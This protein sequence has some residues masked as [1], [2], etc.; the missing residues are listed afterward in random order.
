MALLFFFL[1]F[2]CYSLVDINRANS[3]EFQA[4]PGISAAIADDIVE[5]RF[6]SPFQVVPDLLNV[7]S[8]TAGLFAAIDSYLVV[9]PICMG[10]LPDTLDVSP[11]WD[12]EYVTSNQISFFNC[13]YEQTNYSIDNSQEYVEGD[14]YIMTFSKM[15][16][17]TDEAS[18]NL[19]Q[20]NCTVYEPDPDAP[21][22]PTAGL[23][24]SESKTPYWDA[25]TD[26]NLVITSP[27]NNVT[28]TV[29]MCHNSHPHS[30]TSS[31]QSWVDLLQ[32]EVETFIT[33]NVG[34]Q[35]IRNFQNRMISINQH[36]RL[37]FTIS[38]SVQY[39]QY[40]FDG[41]NYVYIQTNPY[42]RSQVFMN[43]YVGDEECYKSIDSETPAPLNVANTNFNEYLLKN[44]QLEL[45]KQDELENNFSLKSIDVG[46]K[47][48]NQTLS[49]I[50]GKLNK[51]NDIDSG[52]SELN[53]TM[54]DIQ[55]PSIP[56]MSFPD[57]SPTGTS[58]TFTDSSSDLTIAIDNFSSSITNARNNISNV[59]SPNF[60]ANAAN[61]CDSGVTTSQ[62]FNLSICWTNHIDLLS[63]LGVA[64]LFIASFLS[65]RILFVG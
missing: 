25:S 38:V 24:D 2:N 9:T 19:N 49:G 5:F 11:I 12:I 34:S 30:R 58:A 37:A 56:E 65:I 50:S 18:T 59:F 6:Y 43:D 22:E 29:P 60:G 4:L 7:P 36:S 64:I 39:D 32:S 1:S 3:V 33:N 8:M 61:V 51:L 26:F 48:G 31:V 21:P 41:N 44:A 16:T 46:T 40:G 20:Y 62:G 55:I 17:P 42:L 27:E 52:L 47:S 14:C 23:H 13:L 15:N 54:Q 35:T 28:A 57:W 63:K 10:A 53:A 45:E